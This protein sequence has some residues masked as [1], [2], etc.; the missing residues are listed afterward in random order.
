LKKH[1][2]AIIDDD[3]SF[4]NY[5]R[6]FL[7]ARGYDTRAYSRGEMVAALKQADASDVVLLDVLMP[8]MNGIETLR[9]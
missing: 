3:S 4:A 2:V 1:H 5:L 9:L 7:S 8:G 6:T